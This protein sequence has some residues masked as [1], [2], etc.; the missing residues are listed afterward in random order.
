MAAVLG[1]LA[2][3]VA[4]VGRYASRSTG[5]LNSPLIRRASALIPVAAGLAVLATGIAFSVIAAGRLA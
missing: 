2:F 1:G 4:R 3:V 5:R